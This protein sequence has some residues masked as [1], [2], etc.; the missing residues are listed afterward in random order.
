MNND[1]SLLLLIVIP[2]AGALVGTL[3]PSAKA[4]RSWALCVSLLTVGAA[5]WLTS[6]FDFHQDLTQF[7]EW[8]RAAKSIQVEFPS[9]DTAR[10]GIPETYGVGSL[11]FYFHLGADTI[12]L[13]L[14]LLTVLLVPLSIAASWTAITDRSKEYYAWM[15]LL[16]MAMIG[17]FIA[18]DLLLFYIFFELTLIPMFFIIGI[19][20]G[21]ERRHAAGKFF[22]FTF[23]GSV[24][25]LAGVIYL[26]M[27]AGS[28]DILDV[29][30]FAQTQLNINQKFWIFLAF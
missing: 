12:S 10:R 23:T 29:T 15:L 6:T 4:A 8:D 17:C 5:L 3:L 2:L 26:G 13:W 25:T 9:I 28:F 22:L 7:K 24:F 20:G 18:R 27:R 21:S 19:W 30:R 14:V 11:G 1:L 16:L